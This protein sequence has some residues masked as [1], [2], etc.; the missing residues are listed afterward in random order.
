MP[1]RNVVKIYAADSVYHIYNRGVE[2]RKIF[3]EDQDYAVFLKILKDALSPQP[4]LKKTVATTYLQGPTLQ[5]WHRKPKNFSTT[6]ELLAF[7]LMSNHFHLL[8]KQS[9]DR[10]IK[11]FM[12]SIT[13][14]YS[15]YFNKKYKRV[16]PL[17]Q[18]KYKAVLVNEEPYLLHLTRYIHLNPSEYTDNLIDAY[19]SYAYY[20]GKKH[21]QWVKPEFVLSFFGTGT[22]PILSKVNSYQDFVE[23][24]AQDSEEFL[25]SLILEDL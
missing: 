19:S 17:F 23:K 25:G 18:S 21:A 5:V 1:G 15:I 12:Q 10:S 4:D 9:I 8:I 13:T 2:K 11:E 14:R 3:L 22:I 6:I 20:L 24:F 16:G 7:V